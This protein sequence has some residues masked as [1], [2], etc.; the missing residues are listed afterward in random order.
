M[1]K[2]LLIVES[3]AKAKTI[4]KFLGSDFL[5]RS[6]YG[7]VRDLA[8]DDMSVDIHNGFKPKYAISPDKIKV[9]NDLKRLSS[10][11]EDVWL[12]TDED[13]E[14]EAISWHLCE[15]LGLNPK[16]TKRIVFHEITKPAIQKAVANPRL[17]DLNLV[18]AQQARR[19]LDR[20][21]GFEISPILW[22]KLSKNSLSAGRVQSVAVKLIVE[23]E[24]EIQNFNS[25]PYFKI[26][27][28][29]DVRNDQG[30][31]VI[32]KSEL[33]DRYEIEAD[34]MNFLQRCVEASYAI[35][36]IEV[37]PAKRKPA[38]PFTTSTLQQEAS[39]KLGFSVNRT[40]S[41]AQKLYEQGFITYMRT[42]S[43]NLSDS[44][45]VAMAQEIESSYGKAYVHSRQYKTNKPGAQEAH[46]AIRPTYM[47]K[48][49]V[50]GDSDMKRLYD[51]IWKR[52]IASQMSD[53]E[54]ERTQVTIGISTIKEAK[55]QATGE[56]IK[57]EGFLKVYLEG[58]DDDD[59]NDVSGML[60]PLKI[61]Q[62]LD[63]NEM[64]ATE[65]YTRAPGRFTEATLVKQLEEL[66]IGRPSTY[67][68][69]I[70]KIMEEGRGYVIK[71]SREGVIRNFNVL[72]L[73][74][75][76][77][78]KKVEKE[79]TGATK[80]TLAATDIGTLVVDFLDQHFENIM[81]YGFTADVEKQFDDIADGKKQWQDMLGNFYSPF[82][83]TVE[84]TIKNADRVTGER[85]LGK[86]PETGRSVLVRLSR[87]GPV[88]QIGTPDELGEEKPKYANL[89]VGQRM[90]T[91][92]LEDALKLFGLPR[93]LGTHGDEE[94]I[95]GAGRFGPYVKYK[96][97]FISI[98]KNED[99]M[100]LTL[101]RAAQ[102]IKEKLEADAPI[103]MFEGKP[104]TKGKGR[105]GPFIKWNDL[106]VNVPVRFNFDKLSPEECTQL[107]QA[108][109]EKE[110][111]RFI[112]QWSS[113]GISIEN[114]RWGPFIKYGKANITL[115]KDDKRL[116]AE[117][118]AMLTLEEVK[119][120][121]KDE[122]PDAFEP[123]TKGGKAPAKTKAKKTK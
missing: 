21:V 64:L 5:V 109:I 40:M 93:T 11:V 89:K 70:S 65:K 98:P 53:A 2:N 77:I 26:T 35:E 24:R 55:L 122:I 67:A 31:N 113:E 44:A 8:K 27:A 115:K 117:E 111:N 33:A 36:N 58:K 41:C 45:V 39:R 23:R 57:F 10:E 94:I 34:A 82:H 80:N 37:K 46:E 81:N 85:L 42:D 7:H 99:P 86:D 15:V 114:G 56:V 106:Y 62:V 61:G 22:R 108:K 60:P 90:E 32:L 17:L 73:K 107:L 105:F 1:A 92:D 72:S 101:E 49:S 47:D 30:K 25:K 87:N 123:K 3:P 95:V 52:S 102:L 29:F 83:D 100:E 79:T 19:I 76:Q 28:L 116:S 103:A 119:K 74:D 18:D 14:G 50:D 12:A 43:T 71:E 78:N 20:L 96:D 6:S 112:Q 69:T 75:G 91:V 97:T 13:R 54:L 121:I 16:I 48:R 88:V 68:P 38:A 59:D 104:V 110:S 84:E 118:A 4:E 66:G 51:L 63:L 9:V 120:M